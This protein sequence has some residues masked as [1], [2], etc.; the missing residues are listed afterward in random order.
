MLI[1]CA[2]PLFLGGLLSDLAY[3]RSYEVQWNNFAQWLTA[4]GMVFT[5][6]ALLWSLI[7]LFRPAWRAGWAG[8]AFVVL[9]ATFAVGLIDSFA[10]TRDAFGA[11]PDGSILSAIVSL[12]ALVAT[13][14]GFS[15]FRLGGRV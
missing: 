3:A 7:R 10:H 14:L 5:G 9:L 15:S 12:L 8:L 6:F 11:Q 1:A 4:G 13:W 2:L